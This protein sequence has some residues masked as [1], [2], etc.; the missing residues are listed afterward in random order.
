M[1]PRPTNNILPFRHPAHPPH[2]HSGLSAGLTM[3]NDLGVEVSHAGIC[4][5]AKFMSRLQFAE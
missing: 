3:P 2:P 1:L 5:G 4:P